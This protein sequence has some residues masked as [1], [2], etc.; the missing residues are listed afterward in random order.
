MG[1]ASHDIEIWF[2]LEDMASLDAW[3]AFVVSDQEEVLAFEAELD[4]YFE[5]RGSRLMG[6]WPDTRWKVRKAEQP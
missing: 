3:E 1:P 5:D 2:E 6:D 4:R